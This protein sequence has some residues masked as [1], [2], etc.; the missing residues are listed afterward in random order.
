LI[1][2][3]ALVFRQED[4]SRTPESKILVLLAL[5]HL[6]DC[7]RFNLVQDIT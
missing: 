5:R 1:S 7:F 3:M 4:E 6:S 2:V